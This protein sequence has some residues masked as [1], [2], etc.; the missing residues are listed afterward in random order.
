M[1]C[2]T[3][4]ARKIRGKEADYILA[5]KEN[6]KSLYN[7]IKDCFE[8]TEIGEI[9]EMPEDVWQGKGESS[10][11]PVVLNNGLNRTVELDFTPLG[12]HY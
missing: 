4:I 8:G 12:K 7:D 6:Q 5:V 9:R 1:S 10:Q 2:R 11:N 3:G